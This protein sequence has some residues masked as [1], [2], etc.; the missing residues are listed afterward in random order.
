[1]SDWSGQCH[2][3]VI[4]RDVCGRTGESY[5]TCAGGICYCNLLGVV[6]VT[7]QSWLR[8]RHHIRLK[9][10]A[11]YRQEQAICTR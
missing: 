2:Y 11:G 9:G 6:G 7:L 8:A 3:T 10:P 1:M 5:A 4:N